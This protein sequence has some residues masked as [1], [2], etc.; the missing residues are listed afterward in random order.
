MSFIV[1][2]I[3]TIFL[4]NSMD[5]TS[6]IKLLF[7]TL[8]FQLLFVLDQLAD[9]T[10]ATPETP[11]ERHFHETYGSLISSALCSLREPESYFEPQAALSGLRQL[12]QVCISMLLR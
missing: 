1:I 7:K 5:A 9:I 12:H 11:H 4:A 3:E 6:V 8:F 10:S 2:D